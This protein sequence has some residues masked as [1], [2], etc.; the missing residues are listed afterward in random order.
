MFKKGQ[1]GIITGLY[2]LTHDGAGKFVK[3]ME[4]GENKGQY[5]VDTSAGLL[6]VAPSRVTDAVE[7]WREKNRKDR[8]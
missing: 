7:Y 4:Y 1:Q 2:N 5:L 6:C 3:E 8:G